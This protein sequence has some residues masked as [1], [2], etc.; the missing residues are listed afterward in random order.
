MMK[1]MS[2]VSIALPP[3]PYDAVIGS[4][5]LRHSG[6]T[7][8]DLFRVVF[9]VAPGDSPAKHQNLFVVTAPPVRRKW[10][11]HQSGERNWQYYLWDVLMFQ[12]W[13]E[14]EHG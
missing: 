9:K 14:A 5:L 6:E 13:L 3:R 11:E 8:R 10:V 4:G 1:V 2:R 7:L 12:A